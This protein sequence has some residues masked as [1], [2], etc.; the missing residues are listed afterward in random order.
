MIEEEIA[1]AIIVG[2]QRD[3]LD[4]TNKIDEDKI[5]PILK[6]YASDLYAV[7]HYYEVA[8]DENEYVKF[9]DE[10]T[11]AMMDYEGSGA[12]SLFI[13]PLTLA[14][15]LLIKDSLGHRLYKTRDE[16]AGA[17]GVKD[18]I[19]VPYMKNRE[20]T[21]A[22]SQTQQTMV[23]PA[24]NAGEDNMIVKGIIVNLADYTYGADK[25][26][27]LNMFD[28]FDIDFNQYKYLMETRASGALTKPHSALLIGEIAEG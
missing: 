8:Q 26:G 17:I 27:A 20:Y 16:L 15:C 2:D 22:D 23:I 6:D 3:P 13:E 19:E 21:D 14:R 24:G 18:I 11:L 4:T 9:I 1:R 12:P 25:G 10:C 7:R 28:D 5:I